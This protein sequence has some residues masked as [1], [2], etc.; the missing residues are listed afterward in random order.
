MKMDIPSQIT[1]SIN[2][3]LYRSVLK[4]NSFK[5]GSTLTLKV[6]ELRGDRAL[7]DFG[8]FRAT[9]D[10]KIPVALGEKLLV[11]VQEAGKQLRLSI[12]SPEP[13]TS[14][15]VES[16]PR[17]TE[18]M[19]AENFK[20]IQKDIKQILNQTL[21][22]QSANNIPKPILNILESL[23][24]HFEALD[25][26]K[27]IA[28]VMPRLKMYVDNSGVFFEKMLESVIAKLMNESETASTRQLA[29]HPAVQ[30]VVERDLKAN[31]LVLKS[32]VEDEASLQK[33][34]DARTTTTLRKAVDALLADIT[35]QQGRA[36]KQLDSAEPF[37]VFT[38][39]LPLDE[40]K[41]AAKLKIYYQ[42]KQRTG[43]KKGFQISLLLSMDRLGAVR[44]DF[45]LLEKDLTVTFFVKNPST[46]IE[47]Q[48]NIPDLQEFLNPFF[49]QT[50]L[51]VIV[52]EKKIKDFDHEDLQTT[53]DRRVDVL[54]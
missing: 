31:L 12:I 37:Q 26:K 1:V 11:K 35:T 33:A 54:I 48:E 7:I 18:N 6:I 24:T 21:T 2:P 46:K 25:L 20:G 9:A 50:L 47:I 22:T 16:G 3:E 45:Y 43:S 49:N 29:N 36:V 14:S 40:E 39:A 52:S 53:S 19:S 23:N 28:E 10:I 41:Q 44:T 5:P 32:F 51:R 4:P 15:L 34:F 27:I 13:K 42:K 17:H 30:S 8:N 38:Y